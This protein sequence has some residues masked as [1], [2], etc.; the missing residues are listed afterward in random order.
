MRRACRQRFLRARRPRHRRTDPGELHT[1]LDGLVQRL[2][3][4]APAE[5]GTPSSATCQYADHD[6]VSRRC[7]LA[8]AGHPPPVVVRRD[9]TD[10]DLPVAAGPPLGT[11]GMP[12]ETTISS[13]TISLEPDSVV[14]VYTKG[15]V[16]CH[17]PGFDAGPRCLKDT[18]VSP[19]RSVGSWVRRHPHALAGIAGVGRRHR[20]AAGQ[21]RRRAGREHREPDLLADLAFV[22]RAREVIPAAECAEPRQPRLQH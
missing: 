6:P 17:A 2:A 7:A 11:G 9:G 8:S 4:E 18:L 14:A 16:R 12:F 19:C 15:L 1:R 5:T 20:A 22:A 21:H 13:T 3:A 10:Q